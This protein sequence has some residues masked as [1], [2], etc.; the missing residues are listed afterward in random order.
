MKF[1][2]YNSKGLLKKLADEFR[3]LQKTRILHGWNKQNHHPISMWGFNDIYRVLT[4]PNGHQFTICQV[5]M[6]T[7]CSF[8]YIT[9][10]FIGV[11]VTPEGEVIVICSLDMKTEAESLL[12]HF[13]L[14]VDHIFGSVV[15]EAFSVK[16]KFKMD[17]YQYFP[18]RCRA[19]EIDNSS[20]ESND[21]VD[22]KFARRGFTDNVITIPDKV[23][24]DL[25]HQF[26]FHLCP[27]INGILGD[28]NG[29]SAIF[30]SNVS[31][32]TIATSKTAPSNPIQYLVPCLK[33]S[34]ILPSLVETKTPTIVIIDLNKET[35]QAVEAEASMI[36]PL[37]AATSQVDSPATTPPNG[38]VSSDRSKEPCDD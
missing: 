32:A 13:G 18:L 31:A 20:I 11:D 19:V 3:K 7:K 34:P 10:L 35:E 26:T 16:Y 12:A 21:S 9:L 22:K 14:Y 29:D 15:W 17:Q 6:S 1:V 36:F 28:E 27:D 23:H 8:D 33:S 37:K 30:K 25:Q 2:P 38:D 4:A 5:I 24:L